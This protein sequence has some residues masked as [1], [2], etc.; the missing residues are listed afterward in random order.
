MA[1]GFTGLGLLGG[2]NLTYLNAFINPI[3]VYMHLHTLREL[4][5]RNRYLTPVTSGFGVFLL[6]YSAPL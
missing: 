2:M 5:I 3:R 4:P 1:K 6:C